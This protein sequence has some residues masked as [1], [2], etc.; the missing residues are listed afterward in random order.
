MMFIGAK[1]DLPGAGNVLGGNEGE[2]GLE[3]LNEAIAGIIGGEHEVAGQ[4][5]AIMAWFPHG[6]AGVNHPARG[7]KID[8][9][10][11]FHR[12]TGDTANQGS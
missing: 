6:L 9:R 4:F 8:G 2:R 11:I 7:G 5:R 10:Q 3:Q 1:L 12:G